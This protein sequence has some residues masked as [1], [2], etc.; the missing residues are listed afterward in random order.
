MGVVANRRETLALRRAALAALGRIG[1]D[2]VLGELRLVLYEEWSAL[3]EEVIQ[4]LT[5]IGGGSAISLLRD[6]AL[7]PLGGTELRLRAVSGLQTLGGRRSLAA[8]DRI[9]QEV[10]DEELSAAAQRA[11]VA[12]EEHMG[13]G[14][15][16]RNPG[17]LRPPRAPR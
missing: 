8:L 9:S 10:A 11:M 6:F 12:L 17:D 13:S 14:S 7:A 4:A 5:G 2:T 3:G 15:L 16:S 1:N